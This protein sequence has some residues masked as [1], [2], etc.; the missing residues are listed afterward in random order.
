MKYNIKEFNKAIKYYQK[1][2]SNYKGK[3]IFIHIPLNDKKA[4]YSIA[5]LS[6]AIHNLNSTV[7]ISMAKKDAKSIA[8]LR[9]VWK[10][11]EDLNKGIKNSKTKALDE[12]IKIVDKKAKGKFRKIFKKP[13]LSFVSNYKYFIS[14]GIKLELKGGWF[15]KYRWNDL[16]KTAKIIWTQVYNLKKNEKVG[17]GFETIPIQKKMELPIEDYLDSYAIN[18]SMIEVIPNKKSAGAS[19]A[20]WSQ[21]D[22]GE[23]IGELKSTLFGCELEKEIDEPIFKKYKTLSKLLRLDRIKPNDATFGIHG[24]G[25]GGKHLFGEIIGYPTLNKKSR[26]SS[27]GGIVYKFNWYPQ[28]KDE[29]RDP[30]TRLGFTE[31]LPIDIFIKT[32]KINWLEMK[33][34]N[35]KLIKIFDKSKKIIVKSNKKD[36]TNFEVGLIRPNGR[37]RITNGSDV[38]IRSKI[39][40]KY[41]KLTGLK[42]GTMANLPGGEAFITPEYLKGRV[43]GDIVISIDQSYR[44]SEKSPFIINVIK[45]GYKVEKAPPKI[46]KAFDKEKRE[47][48]KRLLNIEKH[49]SLP[50]KII[51]LKKKNFNRIGEFAINTNPT[52]ELCD[53]LIVNEK[54]AGMIHVA[55]GSGFDDDRSTEYHTDVVINAK[56]QK[57]D[58]YGIKKNSKKEEKIWIMKKGNLLV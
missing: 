40:K 33:R 16:L 55:M 53:Y 49:K 30:M 38:D 14:N 52:A 45:K 36:W 5:P 20:V 23:R 51:N 46:K 13:D 11:F 44:L 56:K 27:P 35:D 9:E 50:Q 47:A 8:A 54:I 17:L 32:C 3:T 39:N 34:K 7:H 18:R 31:T 15:V 57:L 12:F 24:K 25:Y 21:L 22:E 29:S 28:A 10:I 4:Y 58:I 37:H 6:R 26:W 19:T 2:L 1:K 43:I 41:Y 42:T 48:W